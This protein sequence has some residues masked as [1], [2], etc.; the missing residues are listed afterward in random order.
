MTS[1]RRM[2]LGG[3]ATALGAAMFLIGLFVRPG[4]TAGLIGFGGIG[5][6]VL[7]LGVASPRPPSLDR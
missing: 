4:G 1:G 2:L 5:A 3:V 7:F 6:L